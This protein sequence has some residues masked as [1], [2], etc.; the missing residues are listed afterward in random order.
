MPASFP[1]AIIPSEKPGA[2]VPY[3][4]K[5]VCSMRSYDVC[6]KTPHPPSGVFDGAH[7]SMD[8]SDILT[9]NSPFE[10]KGTAESMEHVCASH[11]SE[12]HASLVDAYIRSPCIKGIAGEPPALLIS[13]PLRYM[14]EP[15]L[16]CICTNKPWRVSI[17]A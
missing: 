14:D 10:R 11:N 7:I 12:I 13:D 8:E 5:D 9:L 6:L 15:V 2:A 4:S 17:G 3:V 1:S 16:V